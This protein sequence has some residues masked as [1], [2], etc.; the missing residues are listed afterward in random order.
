MVC[1][2]LMWL[3]GCSMVKTGYNN[4]PELLYFWLDGYVDANA[5]QATRLRDDLARMH[6]WHRTEELPKVA[7]LLQKMQKVAPSDVQ[8]AQMCEWAADVRLRLDALASQSEGPA[9]ALARTMEPQQF[10]HMQA[11]FNKINA[12]WR[13]DWLDVTVPQRR[14]RQ[15]K[16]VVDRAEQFYGAL[17]ERQ[18][19]LLQA[20]VARSRFDPQLSFTERLRRQ[21]D[22]LQTLRDIKDKQLPAA[23]AAAALRTYVDRSWQ[24]PNPAHRAYAEQSL[25]DNCKTMAELHNSTTA[26]QRARAIKLL[27]TYERDLRELALAR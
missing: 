25:Q 9:M 17:D 20:S 23:Q 11:K 21:S 12:S 15:L 22:L 13:E 24:S 5:P 4:A 1:I 3:G 2:S 8:P 19:Q 7:D 6:Q 10:E 18:R 27:N 14:E 16:L 26:D